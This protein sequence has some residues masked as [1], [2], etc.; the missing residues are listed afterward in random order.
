MPVKH[1]LS[2]SSFEVKGDMTESG[3]PDRRDNAVAG[4]PYIQTILFAD[5][6][7]CIFPFRD[8][9]CGFRKEE[10]FAQ[11]IFCFL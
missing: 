8:D 2:A 5:L 3:F 6:N 10:R 7:P 11:N 9:A 1:V 4:E